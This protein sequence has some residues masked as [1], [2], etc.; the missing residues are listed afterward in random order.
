MGQSPQPEFCLK[1]ASIYKDMGVAVYHASNPIASMYM[2]VQELN[3]AEQ[4]PP[5]DILAIAYGGMTVVTG[6]ISPYNLAVRYADLAKQ[7]M[8]SASR[9]DAAFTSELL[10]MYNLGIGHWKEAEQQAGSAHQVYANTGNFLRWEELTSIYSST[11]LPQGQVDRS[12]ELYR[13]LEKLSMRAENPQSQVWALEGQ[14][15]VA[16]RQ[17]RLQDAIPL[18]ERAARL[19]D[20]LGSADQIWTYGVLARARLWNGQ[21]ELAQEAAS[22]AQERILKTIPN[23][24]YSLEAYSGVAEVGITLWD[25]NAK[26]KSCG[27]SCILQLEGY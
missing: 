22:L 7:A 19:V 15:E 5:S 23:T 6:F 24:F 21:N 26:P 14:A 20:K 27:E 8:A 17:D 18:L 3:E 2:I 9:L 12:L 10:A 13:E 1:A 16:M 11:L 4:A 25:V